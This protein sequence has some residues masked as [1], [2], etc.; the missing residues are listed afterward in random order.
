VK[1]PSKR[2]Q[3]KTYARVRAACCPFSVVDVDRHAR[4]ITDVIEQARRPIRIST[5]DQAGR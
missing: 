1:A 3:A 4:L 5:L 2:Q